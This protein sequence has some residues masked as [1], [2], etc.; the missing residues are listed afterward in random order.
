MSIRY[1]DGIEDDRYDDWRQHLLDARIDGRE[2]GRRGQSPEMNP[3]WPSEPEYNEW[4]HGRLE[5][6]SELVRRIA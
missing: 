1:Y 3:Y 5:G 6:L 4:H 2:A